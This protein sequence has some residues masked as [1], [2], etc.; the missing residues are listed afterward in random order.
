MYT[1]ILLVF[2]LFTLCLLILLK[3]RS[4]NECFTLN[5]LGM[6]QKYCNKIANV[7]SKENSNTIC[8]QKNN[9]YFIDDDKLE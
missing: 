1:K 5:G 4:W 2:L 6:S 7:Y 8:S 3:K 9:N